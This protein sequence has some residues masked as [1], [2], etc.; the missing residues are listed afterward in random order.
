MWKD[1]MVFWIREPIQTF[2]SNK[3][4]QQ[5]VKIEYLALK[6]LRIFSFGIRCLTL[7]LL[8]VVLSG[9]SSRIDFTK[10]ASLSV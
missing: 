9:S 4:I 10:L 1:E 3:K 6:E 2:H 7:F 5:A 8:S